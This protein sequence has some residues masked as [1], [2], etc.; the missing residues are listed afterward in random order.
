[1]IILH[2]KKASK[3]TRMVV[4]VKAPLRKYTKTGESVSSAERQTPENRTF[5]FYLY[6]LTKF[7]WK[8]TI[9]NCSLNQTSSARKLLTLNIQ[10]GPVSKHYVST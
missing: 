3:T 4:N 2:T 7:N 8:V 9:N 1:M 5:S 10:F 6:I